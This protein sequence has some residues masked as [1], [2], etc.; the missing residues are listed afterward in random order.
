[1]IEM[2]KT[3]LGLLFKENSPNHEKFQ[4]ARSVFSHLFEVFRIGALIDPDVLDQ[5]PLPRADLLATINRLVDKD[6]PSL[7]FLR[8]FVTHLNHT[9][10]YRDPSR[11]LGDSIAVANSEIDLSNLSQFLD[12]EPHEIAYEYVTSLLSKSPPPETA[13]L[14]KVLPYALKSEPTDSTLPI[15]LD[16][17]RDFLGRDIGHVRWMCESRGILNDSLT[18]DQFFALVSLA[19]RYGARSEELMNAM[20]SVEKGI[21]MQLKIRADE[22]KARGWRDEE[23]E[24]RLEPMLQFSDLDPEDIYGMWKN[25]NETEGRRGRER[26]E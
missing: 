17:A 16:R 15:H 18:V 10:L 4:I 25:E 3:V 2:S 8:I 20:A 12:I 24:A 7:E 19:Q 5:L 22:A 9:D 11:F 1:M 14:L 21:C 13:L 26:M 23:A 6:F